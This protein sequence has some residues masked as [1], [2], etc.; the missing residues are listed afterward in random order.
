VTTTPLNLDDAIKQYGVIGQIVSAIPELKDALTWAVQNQASQD[1]LN[2][3]IAQT[4]WYQ[5]HSDALRNMLLQQAAD[6]ATWQQNL[7]NAADLV[8]QTAAKMGRR[9]DVWGLATQYLASGWTGEDLA[10][11]IGLGAGIG[12]VDSGYAGDVAKYETQLTTIAND[13]GVPFTQGIIDDY[14]NKIQTGQDTVDGFTS[15]MAARAKAAHPQF[16]DQFN[17]GMT[18]RQ[19]ADPY[20]AQMSQT[21]EIP[22]TSVAITDP[23]IQKALSTVDPKTGSQTAMPLWQFTRQ[24]KDDPRY[25]QTDGAR[26][27]AYT[28]LGKIGAAFGFYTGSSV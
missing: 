26:K 19:I 5:Q 13:Y 15:L 27:D 11:H 20:M 18:L 25:D 3:K 23:A 21:L 9:V 17:A 6:P 22:Q 2:A 14:V 8:S 10:A 7:N 24:L 28:A 1:A 16:A 12:S 4:S